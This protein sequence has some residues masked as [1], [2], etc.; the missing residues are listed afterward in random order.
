MFLWQKINLFLQVQDEL[1]AAEKKAADAE[2]EVTHCNKK[3][4]TME[5]ELDSVQEKL[6][7]SIVKVLFD[8]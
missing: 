2:N 5:E 7:T 3:I 4:M 1:K 8:Y 6:N